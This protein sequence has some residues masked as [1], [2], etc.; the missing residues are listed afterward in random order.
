VP[1]PDRVPNRTWVV[2]AIAW[3][4][5]L[6][7]LTSAP[8]LY[9]AMSAP[10]DRVYTGLMFD[11]PDHAQYWSWVTASRASLFISNTMTPEPNAP[12]FMNPV[13]WVL[14]QVQLVGNLSFAE[15][16]QVWRF[17][18]AVLVIPLAVLFVGVFIREPSR[19]SA[20]LLIAMLGSGL[21]V[22]LVAVKKLTAAP[23]VPFPMDLYTVE[24][25]T[26]WALLSYPHI[27]LA[28]ALILATMIAAWRAFTR[29]GWLPLTAAALSAVCLSASHAY[30]LITVYAVLGGY[31]FL[32]WIRTRA[33]PRRV[34][35]VGCVIALA[36]APVAL[37]Y[38]HLTTAD[39]LWRA[40]LAQY[41][42]AGVWT[43]PHVHLIVLMG[44]SLLAAI[45]GLF[46]TAYWS[47][48][49]RFI[50]VWA[51]TGLALIYLPVV[52]QIKLLSGWQFPLAVLA[53]HGWHE[54][55]VP[56]LRTR[57]LRMAAVTVAVLGITAT[58][59]Y[60]FA[61]RFTELRKHSAP[62]F[63]AKDD[64]S[65]LT[66]LS[67]HA[68]RDDVVLAR[69]EIGQFVPNYGRTR[70]YLAHW[71]MTNRFFERRS[72][73][74]AFFAA[75]TDAAWRVRLLESEGVTLVF[76][77]ADADQD[78]RFNPDASAFEPVFVAGEARIY[79]FKGTRRAVQVA[80][81]VR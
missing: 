25:N 55:I 52:Y 74:N 41:S 61:W 43:P 19:R 65:A 32:E 3:T 73:V 44:L 79:R 35:V 46:P 47:D 18:A 31:G 40:I 8:Y 36:S 70:A 7:V 71:A 39:P 72:N 57:P 54:R 37:Y 24:P 26:F 81:Y 80:G 33:F 63:L 51:V 69:G 38:Q 58:N 1:A 67:G 12:T 53:A 66:W 48:E 27:L 22:I 29:G 2:Q 6:L 28:H 16:F 77:S 5:A 64:L 11:V 42:N 60:L 62:Y 30:D 17:T 14:A 59:G 9:A 4:A 13:M 50:A 23:D 15:L 78:E 20:A 49:R 10:E 75:T 68:T 21:G 76:R 56:H 45:A 34:A